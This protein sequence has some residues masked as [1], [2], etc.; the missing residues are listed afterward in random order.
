MLN[1]LTRQTSRIVIRASRQAT[2]NQPL[3]R[4]FYRASTIYTSRRYK[5]ILVGVDGSDYGYH[6]L[7]TVCRDCKKTDKIVAMYFP[8]SIAV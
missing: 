1:N 4:S 3:Y 5:T 2:T 8:T 6:A 7:E